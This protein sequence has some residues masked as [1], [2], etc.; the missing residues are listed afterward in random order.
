MVPM[1]NL[2]R[3]QIQSTP[4]TMKHYY[5]IFTEGFD[6]WCKVTFR[7]YIQVCI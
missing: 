6:N 5:D 2:E 7:F 1:G 3:C 4:L